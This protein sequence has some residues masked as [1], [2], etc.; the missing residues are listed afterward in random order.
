M[1]NLL[2]KIIIFTA[3][4]VVIVLLY[5]LYKGARE[6]FNSVR[7]NDG[8]NYNVI[9]KYA[10]QQAAANVLAEVNSRVL[11]FLNYL[12]LKY[13]IN[14]ITPTHPPQPQHLANIVARLLKNYNNE[15]IFETKPTGKNGT[16]YT[17]NKGEQLYLCLRN[18][19][20]KNILDPDIVT[21]VALHELAH[22]CSVNVGHGN[23]FWENFAFLLHEIDLSGIY[24]PV[25]YALNPAVYCGLDI[26]WSPLFSNTVKKIW[27]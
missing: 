4:L 19:K 14:V 7:A 24:R 15:A 23:E 8:Q 25:N 18:L 21:F 12:K 3:I 16:S 11:K 2:N 10:D 20:T 9:E 1:A 22:M 13:S 26:D 17:I 5:V 6:A 27:L